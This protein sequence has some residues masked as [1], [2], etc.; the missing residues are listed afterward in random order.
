MPF[1]PDLGGDDG[2]IA[3]AVGQSLA[4][5]F[6]RPAEAIDRG[7]V[8]NVETKRKRSPDRLDRGRFFGPAPHPA[9][10]GP[11]AQADTRYFQIGALD[12]GK[13]NGALAGAMLAAFVLMLQ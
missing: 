4:H 7:R 9:A 10:N 3:Q 1:E 2:A 6:L 11:G 12:L 8:D 5:D 13:F